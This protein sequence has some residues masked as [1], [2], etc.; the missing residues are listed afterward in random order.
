MTATEILSIDHL[1]KELTIIGGGV[2]GCELACVFNEF[3]SHVTVVEMLDRLLPAV[4]SDIADVLAYAMNTEGIQIVTGASSSS[5]EKSGDLFRVSAMTKEGARTFTSD[6]LLVAAGR[7]GNTKGLERLG[8]RMEKGYVC[9]DEH[10]RTNVPHI[11]AIG[12]VTGGIQ[13][14]HVA[15]AQG[16]AAAENICGHDAAID[17]NDF[18]V[19]TRSRKEDGYIAPY[20]ET[21]LDDEMSSQNI[22]LNILN[23]AREYCYIFTPYL[24]IDTEMINTLILTAKRGVDVCLVTPG[25]PDKRIVFS[26]TFRENAPPWFPT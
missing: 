14:A 24:I 13:L 26:I 16:A 22:Y 5:V 6:E 25:I 21:P 7:K 12:D 2:I 20:G 9:I 8:L 1:P 10:M 15:S 3:G 19:K 4:D 18:R 23:G 17:Y 11:Y